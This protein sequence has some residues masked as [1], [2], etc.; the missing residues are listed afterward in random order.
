MPP[1]PLVLKRQPLVLAQ[2]HPGVEAGWSSAGRDRAIRTAISR[3]KLPAPR[4]P[5]W[6]L[7][8]NINIQAGRGVKPSLSSLS[9]SPHCAELRAQNINILMPLTS[10][11]CIAILLLLSLQCR[12]SASCKT[13]YAA[14]STVCQAT[15]ILMVN[16]GLRKQGSPLPL[17]LRTHFMS[18]IMQ[19]S[20]EQHQD[21][22]VCSADK[23][24]QASGTMHHNA[25]PRIVC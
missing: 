10:F 14:R 25:R 9:T 4:P 17:W 20:D 7:N 13:E 15:S 3:Q 16:G 11:C 23:D 12:V 2:F 19:Q 22:Q 5:L 6:R 1:S 24:A 21:I 18:S 8:G